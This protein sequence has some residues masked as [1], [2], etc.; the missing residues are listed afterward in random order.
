MRNSLV[1]VSVM[2]F[3][4]NDNIGVVDYMECKYISDFPICV[5]VHECLSVFIKVYQKRTQFR[6]FTIPFTA[7]SLLFSTLCVLC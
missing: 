6:Q 4:R 3:N 7:M 5:L 2:I 1:K